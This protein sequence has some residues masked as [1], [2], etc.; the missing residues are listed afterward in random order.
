M[1]ELKGVHETCL[2]RGA[3]GRRH[4]SQD[5]S[6]DAQELRQIGRPAAV[7]RP[8]HR[9]AD[10]SVG[11]FRAS[12]LCKGFRQRRTEHAPVIFIAIRAQGSEGGLQQFNAS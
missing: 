8:R 2:G 1:G 9:L 4:R 12:R 6:L 10:R 5:L 3:V 11:K 7:F